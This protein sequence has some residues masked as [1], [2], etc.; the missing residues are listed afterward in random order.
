MTKLQPNSGTWKDKEQF[1]YM[2]EEG[3][4]GSFNYKVTYISAD[5]IKKAYDLSLADYNELIHEHELPRFYI[6]F[7]HAAARMD[8][9]IETTN[10]GDEKE[11][12]EED[13]Q[14]TLIGES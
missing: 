6:E 3:V 9:N 5:E 1:P 10:D 7:P 11:N 12:S 2:I 13:T 14:P 8:R 4:R